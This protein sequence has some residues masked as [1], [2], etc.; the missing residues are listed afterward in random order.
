MIHVINAFG[1]N[2]RHIKYS[3]RGKV[4][5]LGLSW[6]LEANINIFTDEWQ[7]L[8]LYRACNKYCSLKI[9]YI[10][11]TPTCIIYGWTEYVD[12][13]A[14]HLS[15][16]YQR[17]DRTTSPVLKPTSSH[18]QIEIV[19]ILFSDLEASLF[20]FCSGQLLLQ[21]LQII[22]ICLLSSVATNNELSAVG[23]A[24]GQLG[25]LVL[26]HWCRMPTT[27]ANRLANPPP[28]T[29]YFCIA[30]RSSYHDHLN[31]RAVRRPPSN[32]TPGYYRSRSICRSIHHPRWCHSHSSRWQ[33]WPWHPT[34]CWPS[35]HPPKLLEHHT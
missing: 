2:I 4:H 21:L 13:V 5:T 32:P 23:V 19:V 17:H 35:S 30:Y 27:T 29:K 28:K 34:H 25:V 33:P 9:D 31:H 26:I 18:V 16:T 3:K 6:I 20:L 11:N 15:M 7:Y 10:L 14:I 8:L 22:A 24:L 1:Q 12:V